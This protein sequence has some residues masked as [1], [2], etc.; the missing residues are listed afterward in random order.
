MTELLP[1]YVYSFLYQSITDKFAIQTKRMVI[2]LPFETTTTLNIDFQSVNIMCYDLNKHAYRNFSL[3]G[4][5]NA[6]KHQPVSIINTENIPTRAVTAIIEEYGRDN[7]VYTE[8][9][10]IYVVPKEKTLTCQ[11]RLNCKTGDRWFAQPDGY[12]SLTDNQ[13]SQIREIIKD[14]QETTR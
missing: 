11:I 14:N 7:Q 4:I 1:N 2:V 6:V 8:K 3:R 13:I 9:N 10:V 12:Y 5:T